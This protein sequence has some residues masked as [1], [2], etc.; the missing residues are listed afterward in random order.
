MPEAKGKLT[1]SAV[2]VFL[3]ESQEALALKNYFGGK[4]SPLSGQEYVIFPGQGKKPLSG[5]LA[6]QLL[7]W[8][9]RLLGVKAARILFIATRKNTLKRSSLYNNLIKDLLRRCRLAGVKMIFF[10]DPVGGRPL[11]SAL[12]KNKA[13]LI[14]QTLNA[15]LSFKEKTVSFESKGV[16]IREPEKNEFKD[17]CAIMA[18]GYKNRLLREPRFDRNK[19]KRLYYQWAMNDLSGRVDTCLVACRKGRIAGFIAYGQREFFGEKHG[20]VDMIVVKNSE[21]K[22]GIGMSLIK[23]AHKRLQFGNKGIILNFES[24]HPGLK[25]FYEKA[26][27]RVRKPFN[28]YHLY[29]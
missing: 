20:F 10:R 19:V 28:F 16:L 3:R 26:G 24:E 29:P 12:R 25:R 23:E 1:E 27:F 17:I 7:G 8:D 22:H 18:N 14:S 13:R 2:R 5:V 4:V 9:S 6:Y 15:R 21:R 11:I